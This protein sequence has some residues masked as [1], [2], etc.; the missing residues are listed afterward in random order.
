VPD[1]D[2][3]I[4]GL[5]Q[6][7]ATAPVQTYYPA[8]AVKNYG[9][10]PAAVTG[11]LRIYD[12]A[13]GVQLETHDLATT[14]DIPAGE[15]RVVASTQ[16]WAPTEADIGRQFL[17]IADVTTYRDQYEPNNH[18]P[19]TTVTV[20]AA[21]PPPPP[22]IAAHHLQHEKGG[23]DTID[24]TDLEGEL[25]DPQT[26]KSHKTSHQLGGTDQLNV[27]GL[28]GAL[29][30]PQTPSAHHLTHEPGGSDPISGVPPA[31]HGAA[32]HDVSVEATANKGA[33][34][35]YCPL[36]GNSQVPL[37][38]LPPGTMPG[39]HEETHRVGASDQIQGMAADIANQT[40]RQQ[41]LAG[42]GET[43]VIGREF[44]EYGISAPSHFT[45]HLNAEVLSPDGPATII[46]RC[47]LTLAGTCVYILNT[48]MDPEVR[49][50]RLTA[51]H[52][53]ISLDGFVWEHTQ[54]VLH[55]NLNGI[56]TTDFLPAVVS[57][58]IDPAEAHRARITIE[59]TGTPS[60]SVVVNGAAITSGTITPFVP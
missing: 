18:L 17:F 59:V 60:S 52:Y 25:L 7:P 36:D 55:H 6:P 5:T 50:A 9:I 54:P 43:E 26:P 15:T 28:P 32:K 45:F 1:Y 8:V 30:E 46:I 22:P 51:Q 47:G 13:A 12:K 10:H 27:G 48:A 49:V 40:N 35:G 4:T 2:V 56:P 23:A 19:P 44:A 24:V 39:K 21:P 58:S 42:A 11:T 57:R 29:A 20:T 31:E 38:N 41:I 53:V 37:E 3:G 14:A 34:G 33:A 16:P